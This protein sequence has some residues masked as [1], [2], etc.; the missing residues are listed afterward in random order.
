MPAAGAEPMWTAKPEAPDSDED[1]QQQAAAAVAVSGGKEPGDRR[2]DDEAEAPD[3]VHDGVAVLPDA[4]GERDG[5]QH[6]E[7]GS[8]PWQAGQERVER[9]VRHHRKPGHRTTGRLAPAG[10]QE[11]AEGSVLRGAAAPLSPA[12][13]SRRKPVAREFHRPTRRTMKCPAPLRET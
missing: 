10:R 8:R 4:D 11:A 3:G 2:H 6:R 9:E 12:K 1:Q 13:A 5:Q 7:P